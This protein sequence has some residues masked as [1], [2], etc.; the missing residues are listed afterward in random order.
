MFLFVH[1]DVVAGLLRQETLDGV[2]G[3]IH[4]FPCNVLLYVLSAP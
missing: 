3:G 4:L 1:E 2:T